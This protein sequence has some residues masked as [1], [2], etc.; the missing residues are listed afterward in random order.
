VTSNRINEVMRTLIVV[1][2]LFLPLSFLVG[3]FGMNFL[4]VLAD[5][6]EEAGCDNQN[7][8]RHCRQQGLVH[9]RGCFSRPVQHGNYLTPLVL[10]GNRA[11]RPTRRVDVFRPGPLPAPGDGPILAPTI[12]P[13]EARAWPSS[14]R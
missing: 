3:F 11:P 7:I 1:S 14:T 9:V 12:T 5:A 10:E 13:K 6:L 2:V 8:L 4:A